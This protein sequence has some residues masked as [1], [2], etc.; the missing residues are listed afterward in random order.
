M[1]PSMQFCHRFSGF[2][3]ARGIK[4]E[5]STV[6]LFFDSGIRCT[7]RYK[8]TYKKSDEVTFDPQDFE[9]SSKP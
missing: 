4:R 3:Y 9:S 7:C 2:S 8:T 5:E 1:M 6:D